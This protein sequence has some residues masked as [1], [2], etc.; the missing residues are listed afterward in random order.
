MSEFSLLRSPLTYLSLQFSRIP[1]KELLA[2][3]E[4]GWRGEGVAISTDVDRAG[5]PWLR[6]F[7]RDGKRVDEILYPREYQTML[8]R[9]YQAGVIWRALEEK[10]LIPTYSLMH[11]ISFHDPGVCCPYTVSL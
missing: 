8:Q 7:D 4:E 10:S 6:M 2:A 3:E 1:H 9:G 11:V 5:T